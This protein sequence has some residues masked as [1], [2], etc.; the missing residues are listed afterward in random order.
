MKKY[1]NFL[2]LLIVTGTS[3]VNAHK[4]YM[5]IT[6][7]EYNEKNK[8]LEVVITFFIN[9]L[10]EVLEKENDAKIYLGSEKENV[11]ADDFL[12]KYL[13]QHFII[14]QEKGSLAFN[15]IGKEVDK[16]YAYAYIEFKGFKK[17]SSS[18]LTNTLLINYFPEQTNKVN[19]SSSYKT[20]S[21]TLH[22]NKVSEEF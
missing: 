14:E 12:K 19:F 6:E 2:L 13:S 20:S 21:F 1:I 16:D 17:K 3:S 18:L 7:I 11:K 8:S 15:Y 5:S 4:F 9:D 22:K 10:E